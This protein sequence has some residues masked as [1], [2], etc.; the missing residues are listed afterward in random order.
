MTWTRDP[1][2]PSRD[3]YVRSGPFMLCKA[4]NGEAWIYT[5]SHAGTLLHSGTREACEAVCERIEQ[6]A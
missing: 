1:N 3:Y 6:P 2:D 5:A 4:W